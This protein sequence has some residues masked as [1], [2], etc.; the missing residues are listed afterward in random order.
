VLALRLA[1]TEPATWHHKHCPKGC[2]R[3]APQASYPPARAARAGHALP[4]ST[5][6]GRSMSEERDV[7]DS[8]GTANPHRKSFG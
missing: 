7:C 3:A 6:K 4:V 5:R 1:S 8:A 2:W